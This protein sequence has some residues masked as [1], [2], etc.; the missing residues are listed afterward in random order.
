MDLRQ[1]HFRD[2]GTEGGMPCPSCGQVLSVAELE[3]APPL[4]IEHCQAC[5]G[6]SFNP[7]ELQAA[8]DAQS[9]PL[10][11]LDQEQLARISRNYG[12]NHEVVY[13]KCPMCSERMSPINFGRRS[14]VVLDRC[15]THGV[16]VEGGELRRLAEWWRSGGRLIFE[17]SEG[18]KTKRL[19]QEMEQAPKVL[20]G[21]I[22]SPDR[23]GDWTWNQ[24]SGIPGADLIGALGAI[25]ASLLD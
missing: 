5:H 24:T 13:R 8:L 1:V 6:M 18:D 16:W 19:F 22:E 20:P 11:W 17:Q 15:G 25:A 12:Y 2:L 4:R 10:V 14:G 7:G 21:S 23:I 9:N 3:P